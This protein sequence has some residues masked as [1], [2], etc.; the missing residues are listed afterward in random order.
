[1]HVI[2]MYIRVIRVAKFKIVTSRLHCENMMSMAEKTPTRSTLERYLLKGNTTRG[3]PLWHSRA[4]L[5][6]EAKM[7][8]MMT[9]R[10]TM[11]A[12]KWWA[13]IML[14]YRGFICKVGWF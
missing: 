4:D 11:K 14:F 2:Y 7:N 8:F 1:M 5:R 12:G 9:W 6:A 13:R 10:M 3:R